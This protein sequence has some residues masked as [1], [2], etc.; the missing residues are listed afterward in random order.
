MGFT[1]WVQQKRVH[2]FMFLLPCWTVAYLI[3]NSFAHLLLGWEFH[4]RNAVV[5]AVVA[6][7]VFTIWPS[8][9]RRN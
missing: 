8:G 3:G 5:Y 2:R 1:Q 9:Q 4:I 7:V 6:A